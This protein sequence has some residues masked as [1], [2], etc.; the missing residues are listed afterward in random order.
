M[1][2][3]AEMQLLLNRFVLGMQHL[4]VVCN[5]RGTGLANDPRIAIMTSKVRRFPF[6]WS[7]GSASQLPLTTVKSDTRTAAYSTADPG[8]GHGQQYHRVDD[9]ALC[10]LYT[11]A[12][13]IAKAPG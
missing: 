13:K 10:T 2:M 1:E 4:Y 8:C 11:T 9:G 12:F 5:G 3:V 6:C 7:L